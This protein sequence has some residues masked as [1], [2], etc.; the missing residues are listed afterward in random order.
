MKLNNMKT[1]NYILIV[2]IVIL[3]ITIFYQ[4]KEINNLTENNITLSSKVQNVDS[5]IDVIKHQD[6]LINR[7]HWATNLFFIDIPPNQY[8]GVNE[9]NKLFNLNYRSLEIQGTGGY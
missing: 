4:N 7:Y 3:G 5:L 6:S 1:S 9:F 2:V 8:N